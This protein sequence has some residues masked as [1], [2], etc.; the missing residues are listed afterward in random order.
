MNGMKWGEYKLYNSNNV[1]NDISVC[2]CQ[3]W[4]NEECV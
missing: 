4:V 2:G 3:A 1:L